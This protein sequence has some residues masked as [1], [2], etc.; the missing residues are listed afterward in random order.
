M[1]Y[2]G[3][4]SKGCESCRAR[5]VK[6]D[7]KKPICSRCVKSSL[8]CKYRDQGDLLFRNQTASAA[9][10]AEESWRKRSKSN[11]REVSESSMSNTSP[12]SNESSPTAIHQSNVGGQHSHH[13]SPHGSVE[14]YMPKASDV[15]AP[16]PDLANMHITPCVEPDLR[17]LAY[18]RFIYD[19]VSPDNPNRPPDEPTDS[20]WAFIPVIYENAAEGSCFHTV[21]DAVAYVN[22]ANR[23]S[24]PQAM[25]L[26]EECM[27]KGINLI[28]KMVADKKM[29]ATDETLCSVYMLGVY[30]NMTTLQRKGTFIAHQHGANAL[31]QLRSVDEFYS[32]PISA[33]L[34]EVSYCQMLL[35]NLQTAKRP[36]LH[37]KDV[38]SVER[39]LPS[40]YSNTNVYVVRLIWREANIH[41]QWHDIKRS[42][43]LPTSR[44]DLQDLLQS[45][46]DLEAAFQ[47]W[48]ADVPR[49]WRYHMEPNTPG[50]RARFERKWHEL[51][52]DCIGAPREIHTYP[53]LKRCWIW[54]FY[55]T[56]W[57]FLLRDILEMI[58]WMFRLPIS[59]LD[60]AS[61]DVQ[62][63]TN[64]FI[65]PYQLDPARLG[66][67]ALRTHH[68][69]ATAHLIDV[70]EKSCSAV[71]SNLTVPIIDKREGDLSGMR[72][73]VSLWPLGVMDAIL[74]SGLITDSN[75][76]TPT[77][78]LQSTRQV[79]PP[80]PIPQQQ[81]QQ[82][83]VILATETSSPYPDSYATAPQFTE[84]SKLPPKL[85]V[86]HSSSPPPSAPQAPT[87][88][89]PRPPSAPHETASKG[90]IFD[91]GPAHPYD[92]PVAQLQRDASHT[93][94]VAAR[95][96]WLNRML[97]FIATDLGIKKALYVPV[98]EGYMQKV[99]PKVDGI[100]GR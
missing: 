96:E 90:H 33:K 66:D 22:Y 95:R 74:G 64:A 38:A 63:H 34:Y 24:A 98:V 2:R 3:R 67:T 15:V 10:R 19:F 73:Y 60:P 20:L 26:A 12:P 31:L 54:G 27:A 53:N 100:L 35:G 84:L 44:A 36:P 89:S 85:P 52:L 97:Y 93:I 75:D 6:C 25:V 23:C 30:E 76:S 87:N 48:E 91:S 18:D 45:A 32:N 94:D 77:L 43:S 16:I 40:L 68:A 80:V 21:F 56:A 28:S 58:N 70:L 55:R 78:D 17:Q 88:S 37:M 62:D 42:Q 4:P 81:Q 9:Q 5:K 11:Q 57:M 29:A 47:A 83:P 8:A 46:L 1:S 79:S 92:L 14:E 61:N 49:G 13:S 7:E 65:S 39:H 59:N 72:G 69:I 86:E 51:V 99:K 50:A 41:A 71:F 82:A